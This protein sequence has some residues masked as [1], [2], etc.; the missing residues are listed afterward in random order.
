MRLTESDIGAAFAEMRRRQANDDIILRLDDHAPIPGTGL[1]VGI[2]AA[3]VCAALA[4][5]AGLAVMYAMIVVGG[6]G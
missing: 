1:L 3:G 4:P 2:V 5:L 6:G